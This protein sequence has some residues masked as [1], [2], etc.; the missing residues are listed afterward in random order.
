MGIADGSERAAEDTERTAE[1]TDRATTAV[2]LTITELPHAAAAREAAWKALVAHVAARGS[3]LV[4]LPEMPFSPWLA[5]RPDRED[6][7]WGRAVEAHERWSERLPELG[8]PAI[9]TAPVTVGGRPLNRALAYDDDGLRPLHDKYYLPDEPGYW[10]ASWYDRGAGAFEPAEV[11][12]LRVGVQICTELWFFERSRAYGRDGVQLLVAPRA[13][14]A[15]TE[16]RWLT[17]GRAAAVVSGAWCASSN[18]VEE[19]GGS[20]ADLGGRGWLFDPEG[21][22]VAATT[23]S[24]PFVTVSVDPAAADAAKATY[25]RYVAE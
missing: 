16:D 24:T 25:P 10:E 15:S 18:L 5:A 2:A 3:D 12:G 17:A 19:A 9:F 8:A 4:L 23:R 1:D 13:T 11:A 22:L 20:D 14:P 6:A 7:A 21:E